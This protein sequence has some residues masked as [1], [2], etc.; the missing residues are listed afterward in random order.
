MATLLIIGASRGIGLEAVRQALDA[1]HRVKAFARSAKDI[2]IDH[3]AL[4]KIAADAQ[5][6][7]A[8]IAALEGVDLVIQTLGVKSGPKMML[9]PVDLFS[10]ATR[11]LLPAMEQA[12][13]KRLVTV[14]G[15][16]AG[17]SRHRGGFLYKI[18]FNLFLR[19]AY[20]DKD[21][22]E[23]LIRE[24]DLDWTIVRPVVLYD[25]A[26]T[27]QYHVLTD[28]KRWRVGFISRANVADFLVKQIEDRSYI[29]QTPVITG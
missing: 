20:D 1:G 18:G 13:V 12:G 8:L 5:D 7:Q 19:R 14:T 26:R 10:K 24:S 29:H 27:G 16:G 11:A 2:S 6:N 28:P 3:P 9:Q 17:D 15:F 23:K 22:Q 4:I 25:G 21:V